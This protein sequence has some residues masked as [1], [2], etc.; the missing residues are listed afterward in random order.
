VEWRQIAAARRLLESESGAIIRDWGGRVPVVLAYPNSYAVGMSSLAVHGLYGWLNDLPGV[1]CERSFASLERRASPRDEPM[2]LESQRP[3]REAAVVAFSVSF[4]PDYFHVIA[5]LHAA[6]IPPRAAE[7]DDG[8]PLVILGG[9]AVSANPEPLASLADAVVI[10]EAE[11]LL[12]DVIAPVRDGWGQERRATLEALARIPGVYVPLLHD[13]G[14]IPRRV[15]ANLDAYPL[16]TRIVSPHAEFGDMHLIEISRGCGHGCRFCL[17]GYWYRPIRERSLDVVLDLAREGLRRTWDAE[18]KIGLVAAAVSDYGPIDDLVGALRGMGAALSA[19]SL[20]VN[21][22]SPTLVRA[23]AA[24]G[25]RTITFAPEAGSERLRRAISKGINHDD[26]MAA[27]RLAAAEGF[28][29]LKLYFMVGLPGESDEDVAAMI[30]LVREIKETFPRNVVANVTPFVPKAHT[31]FARHA[32]ASDEALRG[33]LARIAAETAALRVAFRA[34][35]VDDARWQGVLARGDRRLGEALL[36][37]AKPTPKALARTLARR[38]I[39]PEEYLS[40]RAPDEALPWDFIG[41]G[42]PDCPP[43]A[44]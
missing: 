27:V 2:T 4:E 38:G 14:P 24:S 1:V 21:P 30:D 43:P 42:E 22:L 44:I 32:M 5:M 28:E 17:A 37:A 3:L 18:P 26:I 41:V 34:E 33:R 7:R 20:R 13:G 31:P 11:E 25:A 9:P 40:E 6:G 8:D 39:D 23:L 36:D 15:L 16:A 19:S 10:G 35:G 29:T 12:P